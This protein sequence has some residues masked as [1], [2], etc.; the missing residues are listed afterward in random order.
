MT[1]RGG[2]RRLFRLE[3]EQPALADDVDAEIDAHLAM[4]AAELVAQGM[5]PEAARDEARRQ[6]GDIAATRGAILALDQVHASHAR[7]QESWDGLRQDIRHGLRLLRASPTFTTVAVVTLA[8]GIGASAAIFSIVHQVVL[9]PLPFPDPQQLV[10]AWPVRADRVPTADHSMSVP[11]LEDWRATQ[12][13]FVRLG[14]YW[15]ATEQSGLDLTG[16]GQPTRLRAAQVTPGFFETLGVQPALGRLPTSDEMAEGGPRVVVISDGLWRRQFGSDPGIIGRPLLLDRIPHVVV[17]VMP[18]SM[19][20]PGEDPEIWLSALY[21]SQDATPWK[22]RKVRWL[23]VIG[24]LAPAVTPERARRDLAALQQ[25]LAQTYPDADEGWTDAHV[26]PLLQSIVGSVRPALLILLAAAACVLLVASV[27]IAA[28][29]LARASVRERE[30]SVRAAL[31]AGRG[32][33]LQ[34]VLTE[35]L[36]LALIGAVLGIVVAAI[37]IPVLLRLSA[38]ELPRAPTATIDWTVA[39]FTLAIGILSGLVLGGPPAI[40][41]LAGAA[42][43]S[44]SDTGGGARGATVGV[45]R[46]RGR[47]MLVAAEVAIA[48]VLVCGATLMAKSFR[49]LLAA[50]TGFR[51]DSALVVGFDIAGDL[52][53]A[54]FDRYYE[55]VLD[56]VRDVPGVVAVGAAKM[57]PL[58]GL[59]DIYPFGIAGEPLPPVGQRPSVT[60]N[61]VSPDYFR[62]IGTPVLAGRGFTP[63]DTVGAPGVVIVNDVF[64]R[65]HFRGPLADIPG[66]AIVFGDSDQ[67]RVVG[68]VRSVHERTLEAAP[69]DAVYTP[70]MQNPRSNVRLVARVHGEPAAF[71]RAIEQAIWSVNKDQTITSVT[72]LDDLVRRAAARPRLVSAL[73]AAF[74]ALALFLGALGIYG[75]VAYSVDARRQEI[76]VRVALGADQRDVVGMVVGRGMTLSLGGVAIGLLAS[77]LAT[78]LM[79]AILFD[80]APTDPMTYAE[81]IVGLVGVAFLAA[82][83]PARRATRVDAT[84][85]LRAM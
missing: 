81:V 43:P 19:R 23:S 51:P 5:T 1:R 15:Y 50:D 58:Q 18:P 68:V 33:I 17:G 84:E 75:V 9:R 57:L 3:R 20:F 41:L 67:L 78:R 60:V 26:E 74:G 69:R 63:A 12:H 46:V 70:T 42:H 39:V 48:V 27:N 28:L 55:T 76:G 45:H 8:L 62:A 24:R 53:D 71:T 77:L 36:L 49:R 72:T 22:I 29:L 13:E 85:A 7:R 34:Q 65:Q 16:F 11:D 6:F 25:H 82:Y 73:L 54:Q 38:G 59:D 66:Q 31:G 4:R 61:H 14:A 32:R 37:L 83:L 2:I 80:I 79:R 30:F 40:Q 44:L 47:Q 35:S 52:S 64:A 21:E 56:R 10:S